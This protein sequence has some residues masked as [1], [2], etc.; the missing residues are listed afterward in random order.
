[1]G[2][3]LCG[4]FITLAASSLTV[5]SQGFAQQQIVFANGDQLTGELAGIEDSHWVFKYQ[6]QE[7]TIPADD[8]Q[9]FTAPEPIGIRLVDTTVVAATVRPVSDG[10]LL[11]LEDGTSRVVQPGDFAAVG[12][13]DDLRSLEPIIIGLYSPFFKFWDVLVS[14]GGSFQR[15][16]T[17]ENNFSFS[18]DVGRRTSKD[19]IDFS[20]IITT[21][22]EFDD[23][24]ETVSTEPKMIVALGTDIFFS[25]PLF[26]NVRMRWQHDPKKDLQF[27]QTYSG[28]IGYQIVQTDATGLQ[29]SVGAGGRFDNLTTGVQENTPILDVGAQFTQT[30]GPFV[31]RVRVTYNPSLEDFSNVELLDSYD[32]AIR[33]V[34]GLTFKWTLLHEYNNPP[35][36]G[37]ERSDITMTYQLGYALGVK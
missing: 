24:G 20:T 31:F 36:S 7:I 16:N 26:G 25:G 8:I 32:I 5:P 19:R 2:T 37:D 3:R 14:L 9:A 22:T 34:K 23:V 35:P 21:S 33:L 1:M 10:L 17:D 4:V 13:A 12:S 15:G 6:G 27:R 11:E 18:L 30:A 28:G 29:A